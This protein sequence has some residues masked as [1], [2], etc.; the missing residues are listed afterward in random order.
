V[1]HAPCCTPRCVQS[2]QQTAWRATCAENKRTIGSAIC[3]LAKVLYVL[4]PAA[5]VR[6]PAM[7][8]PT[9]CSAGE[10]LRESVQTVPATKVGSNTNR[11]NNNFG[12][13]S[14]A[15]VIDELGE[16]RTAGVSAGK[17]FI[18][19]ENDSLLQAAS[20]PHGISEGALRRNTGERGRG[21]LC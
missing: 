12:G 15:R 16:C 21:A 19:S 6:N 18:T 17:V 13:L 4:Q 11:S 7:G 10:R 1:Q 14:V 3:A 2:A 20:T 9:A 5:I 8:A